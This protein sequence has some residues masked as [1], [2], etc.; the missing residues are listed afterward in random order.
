MDDLTGSIWFANV[1]RCLTC[2]LHCFF[3][4][5]HTLLSTFKCLQMFLTQKNRVTFKK[6]CKQGGNVTFMLKDEL[7]ALET[8]NH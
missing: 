6:K 4:S 5:I 8:N 7:K 2:P 1:Y 3:S